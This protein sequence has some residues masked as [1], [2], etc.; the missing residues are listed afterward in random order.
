MCAAQSASELHA[1][2]A[3]LWM[4]GAAG[5]KFNAST[6]KVQVVVV[7][8]DANTHFSYSYSDM[9]AFEYNVSSWFSA[10]MATAPQHLQNGY[11]VSHLEFKDIQVR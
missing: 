4:P 10:A 11:F 8:V 1:T 9:A 7:E 6:G 2:P 5:P 3:H